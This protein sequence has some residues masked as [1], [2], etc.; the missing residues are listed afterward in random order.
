MLAATMPPW[1]SSS[2]T[3]S[4][5]SD[6]MVRRPLLRWSWTLL[7]IAGLPGL[8]RAGSPPPAAAPDRV[9]PIVVEIADTSGG[10]SLDDARIVDDV[11]PPAPEG[12]A[13]GGAS[14]RRI[15]AFLFR[16]GK[17]P[18]RSVEAEIEIDMGA[19]PR[20]LV[21]AAID[22]LHA[23]SDLRVPVNLPVALTAEGRM[24]AAL[25]VRSRRGRI[26]F[27]GVY[28]FGFPRYTTTGAL[29]R[30]STST[31]IRDNFDA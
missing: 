23:G 19:A 27:S 11:G 18:A 24:R 6:R 16:V 17:P 28:G 5:G 13:G 7:A 26:L 14:T 22:D 10:I 9:A 8:E 1:S 20:H 2:R 12:S 21:H 3:C 29:E 30:A 15:V 31:V 25:V 4:A